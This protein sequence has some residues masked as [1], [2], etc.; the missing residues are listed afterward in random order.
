MWWVCIIII[1]L[2]VTCGLVAAG[3]LCA[4]LR[5]DAPVD[6]YFTDLEYSL[7]MGLSGGVLALLVFYDLT[8]S[9]FYGC[10]LSRGKNVKRR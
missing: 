2:H 7:R 5:N 6:D 4:D 9:A 8:N 3:I 10:S 1:V